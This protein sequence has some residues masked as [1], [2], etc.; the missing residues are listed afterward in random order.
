M[1]N[2]KKWWQALINNA[3]NSV[4]TISSFIVLII[5]K[6]WKGQSI[7][8]TFLHNNT[9]DRLQVKIH[10]PEPFFIVANEETSWK[11]RKNSDAPANGEKAPQ[12]STTRAE[13][14]SIAMQ[15][16]HS[17]HH[18]C[19]DPQPTQSFLGLENAHVTTYSWIVHPEGSVSLHGAHCIAHLL[20]FS[21]RR[22]HAGK[23]ASSSHLWLVADFGRWQHPAEAHPR[24]QGLPFSQDKT[25][26]LA[27]DPLQ[28]EY[29]TDL[30][31]VLSSTC[32]C[33]WEP[34]SQ[35]RPNA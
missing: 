25:R 23:H 31:R 8:P 29:F 21:A 14:S 28:N 13:Y 4:N 26:L 33:W 17:I 30:P 7:G 12:I 19:A 16:N 2:P 9:V 35:C 34:E 18:I 3:T 32:R 20:H 11:M 10:L 6:N 22:E 27:P 15:H 5:E 1:Q 24:S